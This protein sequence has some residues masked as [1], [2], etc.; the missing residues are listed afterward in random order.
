VDAGGAPHSLV[1]P[2]LGVMALRL[3]HAKR[4]A[5]LTVRCFEGDGTPQEAPPDPSGTSGLDTRS[6][7]L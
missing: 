5:R 7:M 1:R 4:Q 3:A 2:D 6:V